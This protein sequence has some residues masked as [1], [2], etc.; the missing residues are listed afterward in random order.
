MSKLEIKGSQDAGK[1]NFASTLLK[2]HKKL[3]RDISDSNISGKFTRKLVRK[4]IGW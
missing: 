4:W 2:L 3:S 1:I